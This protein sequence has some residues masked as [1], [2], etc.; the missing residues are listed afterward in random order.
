MVASS[1]LPIS[2]VRFLLAQLKICY[3]LC[4]IS[5]IIDIVI[6]WVG[7]RPFVLPLLCSKLLGKKTVSCAT[8]VITKHAVAGTGQFSYYVLKVLEKTNFHLVDRVAVEAPGGI[9]FMGL[10]RFRKKIVVMG[11][12][13]I[14]TNIFKINRNV[15]ERGN[16][17]G[18]IGRLAEGKGIENFVQAMPLLL[19]ECGDL[20]ALIGGGGP[21]FDKIKDRLARDELTAK[22]RLTGW[23]PHD[24][25]PR[26]LNELKLFILPSYSEGLPGAVQEAMACGAVVVATPVGCVPDL[27]KDGETGFIMED[28]SPQCIVRNVIRALEHPRLNEIALNARRLIEQ[29]YTYE[30]M[31]EKC[32][33]AFDKLMKSNK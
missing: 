1:W 11:A 27:I 7:T 9:E 4:R 13:Y 33:A 21:L 17:V 22:V 19:K 30:V 23:I 25:L 32:R 28:N 5:K 10:N 2:A 6:L 16:L 8:G 14:D 20:E 12:L 31:V 18:Y 24:E 29:E 26:Y 3:Q 15:L